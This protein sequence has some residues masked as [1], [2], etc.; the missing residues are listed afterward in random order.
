MEKTDNKIVVEHREVGKLQ[1]SI[2]IGTPAKGGN[3]KIYGDF[4]D[5]TTF[6]KKIINAV[7]LRQSANEKLFPDEE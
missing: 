6:E 4:N 1:D 3:V 2:D 5:T 7:K